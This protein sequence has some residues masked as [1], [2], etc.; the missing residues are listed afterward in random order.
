MQG[1]EYGFLLE[2]AIQT[3]YQ[4]GYGN[5]FNPINLKSTRET[6]CNV[7]VV[8]FLIQI[9]FKQFFKVFE[10][11]QIQLFGNNRYNANQRKT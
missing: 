1:N 4:K 10:T 11:I 5:L 9:Y 6:K 3:I 2:I 8:L 7:C